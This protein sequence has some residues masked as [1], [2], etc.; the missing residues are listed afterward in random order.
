M[1]KRLNDRAPESLREISFE[2]NTMPHAEGSCLVKFGNTHVLCTA[3]VDDRVPP[4]MKGK[5]QG[6]VTAE[7]SMLPRA[8]ETRTQ[9]DS[10]R[11]Q[12]NGRAQEIQR[13]VGRTLRAAVDLSAMGERQIII[14]CD[15]LRADGGTRT[16]SITGGFI[17]LYMAFEKIK[18][19]KRISRNPITNFVSAISVGIV[20]GN[21]LLDIDYS[22]DNQADTDANFIMTD[23][24]EII[25]IQA[26]AEKRAF[27]EQ[28]F[29]NMLKLAKSG[30]AR[31]IEL[32][33]VALGKE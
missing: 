23:T 15:V 22:E 2:T 6:W 21:V 29:F 20:K 19:E 28:H 12:V 7:Y 9:R 24:G 18:A 11:G 31:L 14:D 25:E 26:A 4:F 13:L 1:I 27:S 5:G 3:T 17:A 30:T 33:K 8:T 16:A 32:Q 10:A